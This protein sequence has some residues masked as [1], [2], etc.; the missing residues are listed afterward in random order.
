MRINE[1]ENLNQNKGCVEK[2]WLFL[3]LPLSITSRIPQTQV[4]TAKSVVLSIRYYVPTCACF[5]LGS[6]SS[7]MI[8][9]YGGMPEPQHPTKA[10]DAVFGYNGGEYVHVGRTVAAGDKPA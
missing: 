6:V 10:E 2:N 8:C 3:R 4:Q 5:F 1:T 7:V 9:R